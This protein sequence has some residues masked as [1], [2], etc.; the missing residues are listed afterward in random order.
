MLSR[1]DL[2]KS[3]LAGSSLLALGKLVPG[4]VYNTALAAEQG[5]DTILVVIE[6]NGG[7]DGLNTVIP[8]NN[9]LYYKNRP[10]LKIPKEQVVKLDDEVGLHPAMQQG[11]GQMH[12]KSQLAVIQG[13]GYPN[14]DRSHFESMDRWQM[15]DPT[16]QMKTGWLG[17]SINELQ[18]KGGGIPIMHI[19]AGR[20]PLS[21]QGSTHGAISVNNKQPYRLDLGG[22]S[23][24]RHKARRKL[25]EDLAAPDKEADKDNLL[26]FVARREVQT[27][28]TLDRL[29]T[30]LRGTGNGNDQFFDPN[31]G[32]V[33]NNALPP[34]LQL[35]ARLIQQDF[36]TRVFYVMIDGFDTHSGQ[37]QSQRG[38]LQQVSDGIF[39]MFQTL[40]Q[41][42]HDKRVLAMTFS[43]FGRRVKENGSGTDHGSASCMFV[44]GPGVK[45]GVV[46]KHPSLEKLDDGDLIHH[47]DFRQVYATLLDDWLG[48]DSKAVLAGKFDSLGFIKK[49]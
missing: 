28:S 27:L 39:Q 14:P 33:L 49:A 42:G 44:A 48:V 34:K 5:K 46:G 22:G 16:R 41:G 17:R 47:T 18:G 24:E 9:E 13:V 10:T 40:Q 2:L 43:E 15:G 30:V 7:N 11:F 21:L 19:G 38:L 20:L 35:I 4:F 31:T 1:R 37:A 29:Q 45:G 23:E 36:G 25:L 12:Q 3:A 32:R 26:Q 6:L 8:F